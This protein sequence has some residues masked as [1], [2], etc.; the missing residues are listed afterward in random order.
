MRPAKKEPIMSNPSFGK[1]MD[2]TNKL[3]GGGT[4]IDKD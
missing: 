3:D 4:D 2:F 1:L